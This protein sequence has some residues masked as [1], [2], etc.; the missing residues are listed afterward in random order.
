[1]GIPDARCIERSEDASDQDREHESETP[2][3]DGAACCPF[4]LCRRESRTEANPLGKGGGPDGKS[5]EISTQIAC[6]ERDG[7]EQE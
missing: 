5:E 1:M 3:H 7:W 4:P 6:A 2:E